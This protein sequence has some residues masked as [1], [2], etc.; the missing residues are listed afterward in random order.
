MTHVLIAPDK[1]KGTLTAAEVAAH[2]ATG[3]HNVR[4]DLAVDMVPVADGGDGTLAA[5]V[6]AG[7]I[8]VPIL[9][10]GPTGLPVGSAYARRGAVAVVELAQVS[11]LGQLPEGQLAP[12]VGVKSWH[13]RS[14]RRG[15]P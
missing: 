4:S 2:I 3:M 15:A 10:S 12:E 13:R 7:F 11:G 5:A 1:F 9:A 8:R 6:A 14:D